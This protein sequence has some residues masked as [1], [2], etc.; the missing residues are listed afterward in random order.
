MPALCYN[1]LFTFLKRL[2]YYCNVKL[3][4]LVKH[5]FLN[6]SSKLSFKVEKKQEREEF[7]YFILVANDD[8]VRHFEKSPKRDMTS[9]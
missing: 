4:E 3:K 7:Y 9:Y 2:D 5:F 8:F 1:A 6:H